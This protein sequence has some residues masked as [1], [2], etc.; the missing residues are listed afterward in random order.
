[1]SLP[2]VPLSRL[3]NNPQSVGH[4]DAICKTLVATNGIP[5][6]PAEVRVVQ[7]DLTTPGSSAVLTVSGGLGTGGGT[8]GSEYKFIKGCGP[9]AGGIET[10]HLQLFRYGPTGAVSVLEEVFDIA[11]KLAP[12]PGSSSLNSMFLY[13]DLSTN[14]VLSSAIGLTSGDVAPSVVYIAAP[15]GASADA[16]TYVNTPICVEHNGGSPIGSA[17][18]LTIT[19]PADYPTAPT[20][21][22][23]SK[24]DGK[25]LARGTT[26]NNGQESFLVRV[27]NSAGVRVASGYIF[28][29][30]FPQ[31]NTSA[32]L[33]FNITIET[34]NPYCWTGDTTA[35]RAYGLHTA[36]WVVNEAQNGPP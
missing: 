25:I 14:G 36:I 11:P 5:G 9:P 1:M 23:A 15:A 17:P 31:G 26:Y 24:Y 3:A 6:E 29:G 30:Q 33:Q 13:A 22:G 21:V 27:V 2:A 18:V 10:D 35:L 19:L 8:G 32:V 20:A 34:S 12:T 16:V 28:N 7:T 4:P